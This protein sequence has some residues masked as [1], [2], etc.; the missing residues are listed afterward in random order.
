[1]ELTK[2]DENYNNQIKATL[3]VNGAY[4]ITE[5]ITAAITSGI[6]FRE[7]QNTNYGSKIPFTRQSSTSITGKAGFQTEGLSRFFPCY[8]SSFCNL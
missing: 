5:N 1:L 7:T 6:D 2:Y 8:S 4:K 3:G